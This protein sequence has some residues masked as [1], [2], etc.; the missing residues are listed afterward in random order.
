MKRRLAALIICLLLVF[1][2][3]LPPAR[4][5]DRVCFTAVGSYVLPL[6]DNTMPFWSGGYVYIASSI[7]TG[8][9]RET[10]NVS[11][12]LDSSLEW[13]VLY[14][15]SGGRSLTFN[16][17]A[18]CA[19]DNNGDAHYPGAILRN[20]TVF[21][22]AYTIS[23]YFD[24]VYSVIEV[25]QGSMVWLR[26]PSYNVPDKQY[27]SAARYNMNAVYADYIR[28]KEAAQS[29]GSS[30][31]GGSG[32]PSAST[33]P[34]DPAAELNG[35]RIALCLAV[36]SDASSMADALE[37]YEAGA[38]LFFTPED[39]TRQGDTVRRLLAGGQSVGILVDAA[40][41]ERT[42]AEQLEAGNEALFQAACGKTHLAYIQNGGSQ[43]LQTAREMGFRCLQP[44]VDRSGQPLQSAAAAQSLL[45]RVAG[46]K[47]DPAVWLGSGASATG[48]RAFLSS[49]RAAGGVCVAYNETGVQ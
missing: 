46:R 2:L 3:A 35:K 14:S 45:Q 23:R 43:S 30:S 27:A 33:V 44:E 29:E 18:N 15:G 1:Q 12:V 21:V 39:I 47:G 16:L 31:S 5:A 17:S 36:G 24:L 20:G 41:S 4:A 25:E 48:L 10:L 42:V 32:R 19:L 38:A 11:Q 49:A 8:S 6:S 28:A 34:E 9:A 13:V 40:D 22:P 37:T 7:F 26:Q